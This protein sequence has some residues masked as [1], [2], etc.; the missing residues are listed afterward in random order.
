V[1]AI[2]KP[3]AGEYPPYAAM[4]IDLLPDDGRVLA[5]LED[6]A[7]LIDAFF[8]AL[9]ADRLRY[10]YAEGKWTPKEILLHLAD[11]ERI[12]AYRAL[13]FARGDETEL[14]GFDQGPYAAASG[15][16]ARPLESLLIE[17]AAVRAS[18][19]SLF[20]NLP[21]AALM[22]SGVANGARVTVRA[23]AWHIAGHE[24]HHLKILRER[25]QPAS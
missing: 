4:Y 3:A 14:P 18:T 19:L 9:P 21:E 11:D 5:R 15:A 8:R 13:R 24:L 7:R 22:R 20:A 25:Y 1:R 17:H 2:A 6:Q 10:R 12:Y 23:L 16:D